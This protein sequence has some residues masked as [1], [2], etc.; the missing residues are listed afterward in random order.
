MSSRPHVAKAHGKVLLFTLL[1]SLSFPIGSALTAVLDPLVVTW[2]RYLLASLIFVGVLG[3][4]GELMLPP[5]RDLGRYTLISLPALCYFVA[6]FVA[7]QETSALDASALY[8]T[9]PLISALAGMVILRRAIGWGMGLALLGGMVA[10][11]LIIFRGDL[12]LVANLSLTPG[13]RIYLLGCV[14]MALNPILIKRCYRGESFLHL[15]GWTLICATVLLT[16][17]ALPGLLETDWSRVSLPVGLGLG[18]LALFATALSFLL[19]QQGSVA[20]QPEQVSAYTYLIPVMVLLTGML[21]G[22]TVHW[23]QVGWG[24]GGVLLTM[25]VMVLLPLHAGKRGAV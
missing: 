19:F 15:T 3:Y 25:V 21:T 6:M 8:T 17:M 4:Q 14:A 23:E 24:V 16:P 10:A 1:I 12:E 22:E 11:A 13:N 20:L 7:L 18:Y 2:V 9:V 5:L